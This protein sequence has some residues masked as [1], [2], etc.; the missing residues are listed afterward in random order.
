M[1][2]TTQ[3]LDTIQQVEDTLSKSFMLVNLVINNAPRSKTDRTATTELLVGKGARKGAA[4]AVKDLF[5]GADGEIKVI[6]ALLNKARSANY[7]MTQ[8]YELAGNGR[9]LA[10]EMV[11]A[12]HGYFQTMADIKAE[13]ALELD[14]FKHVYPLRI[15]EAIQNLGGLADS[16]DYLAWDEFRA[17]IGFE[18]TFLPMTNTRQWAQNTL[19]AVAIDG[20]IARQAKKTEASANAMI[21]TAVNRALEPIKQLAFSTRQT[22]EGEKKG[23]VYE[24]VLDNVGAMVR[25]LRQFNIYKDSAIEALC[26]EVEAYVLQYDIK[27]LRA[28]ETAKID[29]H[30][31]STQVLSKFEQLGW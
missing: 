19:D 4:K 24:G 8:P 18:F 9:V 12:E 21:K 22:A 28:S 10:N 29:V 11:M 7:E 31:A 15:S 3:Q 27:Q 30:K 5:V 14:R 6:T 13:L 26:D 16:A 23:R 20:L 2:Y 1:H 17:S 25:N